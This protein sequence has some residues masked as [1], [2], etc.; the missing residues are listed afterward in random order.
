MTEPDLHRTEAALALQ[1]EELLRRRSIPAFYAVDSDLRVHFSCGSPRRPGMDRLPPRV[2]RMARALLDAGAAGPVAVDG[3]LAVRIVDSFCPTAKLMGLV[4]ESTRT[5]DPLREAIAR[6]GI[7]P[8]ETQVLR[9][10][11][12]GESTAAIANK[13]HI[14]ENTACDHVRRIA[15]KTG[16]RGRGQIVARALGLL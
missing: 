8:R 7:T 6:F 1:P 5:R 10:L 4:V 14:A 12:L 3:D 2:E 15:N 9:L 16:S 13:L 11:L